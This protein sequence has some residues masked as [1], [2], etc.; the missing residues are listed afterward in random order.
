VNPEQHNPVELSHVPVPDPESGGLRAGVAEDFPNGGGNRAFLFTV[1]GPDGR[2]SWFF[3]NSAST[4]DLHVPS[5]VD[6]IERRA[7]RESQARDA[8]RRAGVR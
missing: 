5:G 2:F 7:P 4:V 1:D 3:N 6:G 8:R